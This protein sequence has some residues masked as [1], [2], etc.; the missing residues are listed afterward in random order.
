MPASTNP[1]SLSP[2]LAPRWSVDTKARYVGMR[3]V[4]DGSTVAVAAHDRLLGL[5]AQDGRELWS[6]PQEHPITDLQAVD[7]GPVVAIGQDEDTE[8]LAYG[9]DGALRWR[10]RSG[11]GIGMDGLRGCGDALAAIGMPVGRSRQQVCQ[12][13]AGGSGDLLLQFACDGDVPDRVDAGWLYATR[14]EDGAG[15]GLFLHRDDTKKTRRLLDRGSLVRV[16]AEG[17]AVVD[18]HDDDAVESKLVAVDLATGKVLWEDEG[19]PN[20]ALA[21]AGGQLACAVAVDA[22]HLAMTLRELRTGTR[23]WT[24]A[25]IAARNVA[26]LLAADVVVATIVSERIEVYARADGALVQTLPQESSLV[27]G[28][29]LTPHGLIDIP[30]PHVVCLADASA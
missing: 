15:G 5:A 25:P 28:G 10:V 6:A 8:L 14:A 19:G 2:P 9:W 29:C 13:R 1:P 20:F 30:S 21:A 7:G 26:A 22:K 18:T 3:P 23:I 16:V 17:V 11:I 24:A 12:V 4:S 27:A